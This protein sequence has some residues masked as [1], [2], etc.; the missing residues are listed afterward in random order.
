[1]WTSSKGNSKA[2]LS[3]CLSHAY[4]NNAKLS[5]PYYWMRDASHQATLAV[6]NADRQG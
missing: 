3:A 1:M 4:Y 5:F 6:T 2:W